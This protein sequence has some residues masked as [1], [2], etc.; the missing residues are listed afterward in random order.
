MLGNNDGSVGLFTARYPGVVPAGYFGG[1]L[2]NNGERIALKD[3]DGRTVDSV[4]YDDVLPWPTSPDGGGTSLELID[5]NGDP[6]SYG[7]WKASDVVKGTPGQ[8][9]SVPPVS[10]VLLN[11]VLAV[12]TGGV[13]VSGQPLG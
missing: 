7:N 1:S 11:E 9:N 4:T 2:D 6:D 5:V 3:A 10:A 12:N 8:A 13:L